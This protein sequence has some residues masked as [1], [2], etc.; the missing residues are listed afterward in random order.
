MPV[1][2]VLAA[3]RALRTEDVPALPDAAGERGEQPGFYL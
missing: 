3:V 1:A 2:E